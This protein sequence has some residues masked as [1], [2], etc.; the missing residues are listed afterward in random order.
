M[1]W[2]NGTFDDQN[3]VVWTQIL[4]ASQLVSEH[5]DMIFTGDLWLELGRG[6]TNRISHI[7]SYLP[8]FVVLG[9]HHYTKH[10]TPP[11]LG[12]HNPILV[13]K[14]T[15]TLSHNSVIQYILSL[16]YNDSIHTKIKSSLLLLYYFIIWWRLLK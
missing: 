6:E 11:K 4:G 16:Y 7:V 5:R 2:C 10:V 9:C 15:I 1:R 8:N 13:I 14:S 3:R 12:P